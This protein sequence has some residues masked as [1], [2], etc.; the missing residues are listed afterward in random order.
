MKHV[1]QR[2]SRLTQ[3]QIQRYS[4]QFV[5]RKVDGGVCVQQTCFLSLVMMS[6]ICA[7]RFVAPLIIPTCFAGWMSVLYAHIKLP[8]DSVYS[9]SEKLSS[10]FVGF[11]HASDASYALLLSISTPP[12]LLLLTMAQTTTWHT[13]H[14]RQLQAIFSSAKWQKTYY[15]NYL[16]T[17]NQR[18]ALWGHVCF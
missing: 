9:L 7:N 11:W 8:S 6:P 13:S 2:C 14:Y 5:F 12:Q 1:N 3:G 17:F 15:Y 16:D 18:L 10:C 4:W